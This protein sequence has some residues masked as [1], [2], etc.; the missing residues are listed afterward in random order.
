MLKRA[1][2]ITIDS[3]R[4][5]R[6]AA[7]PSL[8][9]K[10]SESESPRLAG[11]IPHVKRNARTSI[12]PVR[13]LPAI[14]LL[15]GLPLVLA[16]CGSDTSNGGSAGSPSSAGEGGAVGSAG[17]SSAA[18][19]SASGSAAIAGSG[20]T[21]AGGASAG[22]ASS[23]AGSSTG[24]ASAGSGGAAGGVSGGSG[25]GSSAGAA[26]KAGGP[27]G[28]GGGSTTGTFTLTS[29]DHVE[30]AKFAKD[31]T[32]D[33]MNG[34]FGSGVNPEL[35]WS[36]APNG[37]LSFAITFIDT[38]LASVDP[39]DSKSQHW[40]IWNIPASVMKFPKGTGMTLSGDLAAAKQTG[41][42]LTPCAQSLMNGMDDQYEFTVY[43]LS[44]AMLTVTGTT[45][46]NALAALKTATVL[47]KAT[48]HGHAGLKGK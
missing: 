48:L 33:A 22:A 8:C 26:G 34:T 3:T 9:S 11:A 4:D 37:T 13:R 30:G 45:V 38:T 5:A 42:F 32:C 20:N 28:S 21:S 10:A 16:H 2:P 27:S 36:G 25:G 19:S 44:S 43:A 7:V 46:A 6:F 15:V 41:K 47:G 24:G 14:A 1:T 39:N 17:Q 40:A 18:G 31:Y 23:A 35:D 29:P 12:M